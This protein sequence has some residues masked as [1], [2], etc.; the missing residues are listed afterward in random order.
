M[1]YGCSVMCL[2][3]VMADGCEERA[4]VIGP[5]TRLLSVVISMESIPNVAW[6]FLVLLYSC[7][8]IVSKEILQAF[9]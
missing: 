9:P 3:A 4:I 7:N 8:I 2:D 1:S 6:Y 5:L